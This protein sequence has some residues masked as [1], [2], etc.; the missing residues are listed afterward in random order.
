[1]MKRACLKGKLPSEK[2]IQTWFMEESVVYIGRDPSA[3]IPIPSMRIS[4]QHARVTQTPRGYFIEDLKSRNGTF[5]NGEA[6]GA[7]PYRLSIGDEIVLGGV[8]VFHFEDPYETID[9]A[10]LGRV[11]GIWINIDTQ[12]VWVDAQQITP[13]LSKAQ[14]DL[15]LLLYQADGGVVSRENI[16]A[17]VWPDVN[18]EG[19]S[20]DAVNGLIK[21]LRARLKDIQPKREYI[22]ILRGSGLRLII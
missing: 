17:H 7:T 11:E 12:E 20:A 14:Y 21:R 16:V 6:L 13:P 22:E 4:R 5:V 15:L 3:D 9:G 8:A 1:M 2:E 19:V 10:M 18:P